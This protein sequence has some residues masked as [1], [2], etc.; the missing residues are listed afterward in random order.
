MKH[1]LKFLLIVPAVFLAACRSDV[2]PESPDKPVDYNL[3]SAQEKESHLYQ[4]TITPPINPLVPPTEDTYTTKGILVAAWAENN[5]QFPAIRTLHSKTEFFLVQEEDRFALF[6]NPLLAG[7][8]TGDTIAVTGETCRLH[9]ARAQYGIRMT[10]IRLLG[11]YDPYHREKE[12]NHYFEDEEEKG[13]E[14]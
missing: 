14:E 9:R 12:H 8:Q 10:E 3:L 4:D 7:L 13:G 6:N 5:T 2:F 11:A 1:L